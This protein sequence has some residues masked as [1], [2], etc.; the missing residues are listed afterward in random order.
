MKVNWKS[1]FAFGQQFA[2]KQNQFMYRVD[3][4]LASPPPQPPKQL[5]KFSERGLARQSSDSDLTEQTFCFDPKKLGLDMFLYTDSDLFF[6][7]CLYIRGRPVIATC[8]SRC[9]RI[10]TTQTRRGWVNLFYISIMVLL[11]YLSQTV[12]WRKTEPC[13]VFYVCISNGT[14]WNKLLQTN[15]TNF[16]RISWRYIFP[17]YRS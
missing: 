14:T 11:I 7:S 2:N 9:Q 12:N 15:D 3:Y 10:W 13:F 8:A 4:L 16:S 17:I 5:R 6:Y 1:S